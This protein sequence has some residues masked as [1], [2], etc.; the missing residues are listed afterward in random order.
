MKT[1][2]I[3]PIGKIARIVKNISNVLQEVARAQSSLDSSDLNISIKT[4]EGTNTIILLGKEII[5]LSKLLVQ[6]SQYDPNYFPKETYYQLDEQCKQFSFQLEQQDFLP[7]IDLIQ[8][9]RAKGKFFNL[10]LSQ[11]ERLNEDRK[12]IKDNLAQ[13]KLLLEQL[14]GKEISTQMAFYQTDEKYRRTS[15]TT[16]IVELTYDD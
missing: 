4:K 11:L 10:T 7:L 16:T 3:T 14:P 9:E 1:D 5:R 6:F 2:E 15:P 13:L 8:E 12:K